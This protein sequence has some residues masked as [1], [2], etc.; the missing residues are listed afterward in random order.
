MP[1]T[2]GQAS[3]DAPYCLGYHPN[4]STPKHPF[5]GG[6]CDTHAHICGPEASVPYHPAR[7]YTPPDALLPAYESMFQSLTATWRQRNSFP[8]YRV[9]SAAQLSLL[10]D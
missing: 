2:N 3:K 5:P 6:A 8:E 9:F 7:I 4:P 10:L 1:L